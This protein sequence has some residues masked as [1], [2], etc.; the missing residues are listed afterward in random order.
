M[1]ILAIG[2][3]PDDIE[4]CCFGTLAK[5][6]QGKD[7][8]ILIAVTCKG[9][10][11]TKELNGAEISKVR[12]QEAKKAADLIGAEYT[13]LGFGDSQVFFNQESLTVFINLIRRVN[14]DLIIT[15]PP[16]EVNLHNDHYL[17]HQLVLSASIW[18]THH[19]LE[20]K[21]EFS[22]IEKAA[23]IFYFEQFPGGFE[24]PITHYV[25]IT[26]TFEI[27]KKA[28][29][30]HQSQISFTGKLTGVNIAEEMELIA[31][32][33]G[34]ECGV[35]YAEAFQELTKYPHVRTERLLP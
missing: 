3:H 29:S 5:F 26:S 15:H 8:K 16:N 32:K 33:R 2:A 31:K 21:T 23:S 7:N 18:A 25:D 6:A 22:P 4:V 20:M 28:L 30:F 14:P 35:K 10:A 11:G 1:K 34:M 12:F 24:G 9:N 27:K 13:N 17:T 19:N